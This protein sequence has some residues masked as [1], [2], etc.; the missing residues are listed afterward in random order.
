MTNLTTLTK[1]SQHCEYPWIGTDQRWKF[2]VVSGL[3]MVCLCRTCP[4]I[5]RHDMQHKEIVWYM[6]TRREHA[7][8]C[9]NVLPLLG[10]DTTCLL[11][12]HVSTHPHVT[13]FWGRVRSNISPCRVTQPHHAVMPSSTAFD[14]TV[15]YL[16][17]DSSKGSNSFICYD[18][19]EQLGG[20]QSAPSQ[21]W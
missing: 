12:R 13:V 8:V 21:N 3:S 18:L 17:C 7:F 5:K 16:H 4:D 1:T 11:W 2:G 6:V 14:R 15:R 19:W 9:P 20:H 10:R